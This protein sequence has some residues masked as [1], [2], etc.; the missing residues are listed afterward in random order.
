MRRMTRLLISFVLLLAFSLPL[1]ASGSQEEPEQEQQARIT[2][3]ADLPSNWRMVGGVAEFERTIEEKFNVDLELIA[4][5]HNSYLEKIQ[6]LLTSGD[7]PDL[8]Q[9][10]QSYDKIP[11]YAARGMI[12]PLTQQIAENPNLQQIPAALFEQNTVDGEIYGVPLS[13]TRAQVYW[14]REDLLQQYGAE[15]PT[16]TDEF[17]AEMSKLPDG[18]IP[19]VMPKWPDNQQLN[20]NAF[21]AYMYLAQDEAGNW[22]DG[23][24]TPEAEEAMM[25]IKELYDREIL[26]PLFPTNENSTMRE[27]MYASNG[28]AANYWSFYYTY[29]MSRTEDPDAE[30]VPIYGLNGGGSANS[31]ISDS[32]AF[33]KDISHPDK[34]AEIVGYLTGTVEGLTL[35]HIGKEGFQY[36]VNDDGYI[37][38]TEA[39]QEGNASLNF[40]PLIEAP[41]AVDL[42]KL[43]FDI[44][45]EDGRYLPRTIEIMRES[46]ENLG[47]Q[48]SVPAGRSRIWDR[49]Q[50]A[51]RDQV[52]EL[53]IKVVTGSQSY[54]DAM[55]SYRNFWRSINGDEMLAQ[56]NQ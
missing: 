54:E 20:F 48:Y 24:Q 3:V 26:D 9:I 21:G 42:E 45:V 46:V 25:W 36:T 29:F 18:I 56:L 16:T 2:M 52:N 28:A 27:K 39:A 40:L 34:V 7:V 11:N 43:P 12:A 41:I 22:H 23:I 1:M 15:V 4:P 19:L 35:W 10:Q 33:G 31:G 49:N 38:F 32:W 51:Y 13:T 55:A 5:P 50:T 8:F 37:E 17:I 30:Y 47:P 14:V 6:V 44:P 53:V